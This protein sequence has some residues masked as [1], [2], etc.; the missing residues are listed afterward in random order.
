MPLVIAGAPVVNSFL[1]MSM[2][3]VPWSS[4]DPIFWLGLAVIAAGGYLVLTN[5]PD[6]VR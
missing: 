2:N 6:H 5:K 1:V 4:I 3:Q